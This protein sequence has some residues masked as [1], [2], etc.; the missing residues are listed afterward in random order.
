MYITYDDY[1]AIYGDEDITEADFNRLGFRAQRVLDDLTT[2]VDG[3]R[4]LAVAMPTEEYAKECVVRCLG[5]LIHLSAQVEATRNAGAAAKQADGTVAAS[6]AVT[7]VSSGAESM[8]FASGS[9]VS[10]AI[11][12]AAGSTAAERQLYAA[13]IREYLSGIDDTNGVRLLFGGRYP[14]ALKG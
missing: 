2:G 6:N 3:V 11:R 5:E 9:A 12:D 7:S 8:T 14:V 13:T 10:S 1:K 4:K